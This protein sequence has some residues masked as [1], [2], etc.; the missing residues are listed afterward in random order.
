MSLNMQGGVKLHQPV[1]VKL[2]PPSDSCG[3]RD[4]IRIL[5]AAH[6]FV[7]NRHPLNAAMKTSNKELWGDHLDYIL[8]DKVKGREISGLNGQVKKT[9]A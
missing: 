1:R 3:L 8:G 5:W 2:T 7:K 9:S 4:R 6:E